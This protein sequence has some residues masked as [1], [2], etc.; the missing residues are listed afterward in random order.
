[1]SVATS[2]A[3]GIAAGVGVAG[4]IGS[5]AIGANA[6]ESAAGTQASAAEQAAQ[7]QY[8]E[9][10]QAL[11]FQKQQWQ[12]QQKNE[13]PFLKAGTQGINSLAQL[14]NTPGEGLLTPWT[15]Q[16]QAPTLQ[17]AEQYPGYQFQEQQGARAIEQNAAAT[18]T[19]ASPQTTAAL[20]QYNQGLAQGDYSNVYNQAMQQYQQAY[21]IFQQNQANQYN[22]LSNL[23]GGGQV[24]AG[25][26]GNEGSA[27]SSQV[28]NIALTGGAQQGQDI[29]N[30]AAARASG[31]IGAA[32]AFSGI[33]SSLA[34]QA[35]LLPLYSQLLNSNNASS[36]GPSP[37]AGQPYNPQDITNG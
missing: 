20:E 18:G 6:A 27:A 34:S 23:A 5:A 30:A 4:S 11:A 25:Q 21:N 9:Q 33:P 22:R 2:T 32:N 16:F 36:T 28:A 29:Q 37:F 15:E 24:A 26:L 14:L 17:E 12:T 7:L 35:S 19:L 10:Q 3:I 1:L 13:A 8:Q 31:Y